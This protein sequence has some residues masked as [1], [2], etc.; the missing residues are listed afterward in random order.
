MNPDIKI[1][2]ALNKGD[3][4]ES[5]EDLLMSV[6]NILS[7]TSFKNTPVFITSAKEGRNVEELFLKLYHSILE[8][9]DK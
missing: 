2:A 5:H 9:A 3:L 1:V 4:S 8:G 6:K 7:D